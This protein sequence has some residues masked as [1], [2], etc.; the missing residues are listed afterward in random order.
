[1]DQSD[2]L[3][4]RSSKTSPFGKLT[5]ENPKV[6]I[7]EEAHDIIKRRA[8]SRGMSVNEYVRELLLINAYGLEHVKRLSAERLDFIAGNGMDDAE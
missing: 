4:M 3:F 1:M 5:A 2:A 7:P 8:S 6:L